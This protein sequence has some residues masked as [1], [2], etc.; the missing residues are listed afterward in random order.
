[1]GMGGYDIFR[2]RG[3][4]SVWETPDNMGF[5]IN[6]T[7]DDRFFQPFN[8]DQ[9]GYYS[10]TTEY[11][12]KNIFYLTLT[13]PGLNKIYELSGNY[14]LKDT[15]VTFDESNAIYLLDRITGDTLDT[16][17]PDMFNGKYNFIVAPGKF[18]LIYTGPR[19]FY[20]Q[21]IDT[22]VVINSPE[23]IINLKDI[24]L[25]KKPAIIYEKLD[26]SDIPTVAAIDSSILIKNLRVYDVTENDLQ[27]TTI[28]YYTVQVMALYNPVDISYFRYVSDIKVFYSE[29][30]LF[31]RYTTGIFANKGDAYAHRDDLI[32]KGYPDDLFI[33]KVTRMSGEKPVPS[34]KY[35]TIQLTAT[36]VPVDIKTVFAGLKGVT[37]TQEIDGKYHYLYGRYTSSTEANTVM[38]RKQIMEFKDAFVREITVLIKK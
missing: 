22:S 31:Y 34:Q 5:P 29:T 27:D 35:Y 38:Q 15:V 28:L 10:I 17:Y 3:S 7:D 23:R 21:T 1:M 24:V 2:S 25:D 16:G 37:E 12:K 30:D 14:S 4:G 6:S 11:K 32:N 18:R 8:N 13:N 26:L 33:K 20:P 19:G 36:S 9:N